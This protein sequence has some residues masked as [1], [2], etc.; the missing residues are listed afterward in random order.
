MTEAEHLATQ[1]ARGFEPGGTWVAIPLRNLFAGLSAAEA[2]ARPVPGTHTVWEIA[3]HLTA[4]YDAARRRLG[5]E[6]VEY[7]N[8]ADWPAVPEPTAE[9]WD[10]TLNAMDRARSALVSAVQELDDAALSASLPGKLYGAR[11]ML[12]G[13]AQ[14]DHYHAGQALVLGRAVRGGVP[15]AG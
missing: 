11:E 14:H 15:A 4:W 12:H 9:N 13:I 8:D 1:I 5:G 6:R 7:A 3:L 2:A 10:A